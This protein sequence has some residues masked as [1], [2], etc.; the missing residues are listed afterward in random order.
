MDI[1]I[2]GFH[3]WMWKGLGLV[4]PFSLLRLPL[5]D[6]QCIRS[7]LHLSSVSRFN[8][9]RGC[10]VR[11][12]LIARIW[13]PHHRVDDHSQKTERSN[14]QFAQVS[15]YQVGQIFLATQKASGFR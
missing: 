10:Y 7:L 3:S 15:L 8:M 9:A 11:P 6:L 14:A 5:R 1:T 2:D 12:I 13:K 4:A